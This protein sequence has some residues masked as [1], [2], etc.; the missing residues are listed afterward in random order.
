MSQYS[1]SRYNYDDDDYENDD[2]YDGD[3][4]GD[5]YYDTDNTHADTSTLPTTLTTNSNSDDGKDENDATTDPT[6]QQQ[7][8]G[9]SL[10]DFMVTKTKKRDRKSPASTTTTTTEVEGIDSKQPREAPSMIPPTG[11]G[12][13]KRGEN[14]LVSS[15][16]APMMSRSSSVNTDN[17]DSLSRFHT[18]ALFSLTSDGDL[19]RKATARSSTSG[20]RTSSHELKVAD[21]TRDIWFMIF[22]GL[23][24]R[25]LGCATGIFT[26]HLPIF[27]SA[28]QFICVL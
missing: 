14:T 5:D 12:G 16:S 17:V 7:G 26:H 18:F 21:T 10:A 3:Y 24:P 28:T 15:S 25:S 4:E 2:T 20:Y 19:I 9:A 22:E 13:Q 27:F 11:E 23:D 8:G 1:S 6:S